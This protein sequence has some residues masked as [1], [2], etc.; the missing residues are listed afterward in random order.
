MENN[1][2]EQGLV[3]TDLYNGEDKA[4]NYMNDFKAQAQDY[5]KQFQ[6]A[7]MKAKDFAAEKFTQVSDKI[8]E[9][10]GKDPQELINDAKEYARQKPGQALLVSAAVGLVLGLII[11]GRR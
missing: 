10:D 6:D 2:Q 8:K 9:L 3:K 7:A 4:E 5:G 1:N 11:K